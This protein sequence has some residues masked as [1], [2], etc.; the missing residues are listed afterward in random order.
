MRGPTAFDGP[1]AQEVR[2]LVEL[3]RKY[4]PTNFFPPQPEHPAG[5]SDGTS[6]GL[7]SESTGHGSRIGSYSPG[8]SAYASSGSPVSVATDAPYFAATSLTG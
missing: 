1:T 7:A 4:D 5:S 2:R 6:Q 8:Q 3:K